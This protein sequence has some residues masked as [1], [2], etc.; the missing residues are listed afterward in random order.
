MR[1]FEPLGGTFDKKMTRP[2]TVCA[3][4]PG[5]AAAAID[6]LASREGMTRS[7]WLRAA[8]NLKLA[9]DQKIDRVTS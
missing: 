1:V 6:D 4:I 9:N 8:I 5:D 2:T 3:V 7:E